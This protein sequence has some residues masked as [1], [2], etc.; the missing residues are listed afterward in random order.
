MRRRLAFVQGH[1][2]YFLRGPSSRSL[3]FSLLS[4]R[5]I[6]KSACQWATW[7]GLLTLQAVGPDVTAV[8]GGAPR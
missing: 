1:C 6:P 5:I 7:P 2:G 4:L 3:S 8:W